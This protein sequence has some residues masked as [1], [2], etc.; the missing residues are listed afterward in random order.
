M[1]QTSLYRTTAQALES[2]SLLPQDQA[3]SALALKYAMAIDMDL[4]A[5]DALGPKLLAALAA[6]GMTPASRGAKGGNQD[7]GPVV[8]KLD[9]LQERRKTRAARAGANGA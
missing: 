9:E 4:M 6:L 5:L 2:A 7:A 3:A 8:S 1:E